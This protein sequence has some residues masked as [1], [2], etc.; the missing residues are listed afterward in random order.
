M[1]KYLNWKTWFVFAAICIVSATL[2]YTHRLAVQLAEEETK[3]MMQFVEGMRISAHTT[4]PLASEYIL[5]ILEQNTKIPMILTD[6]ED[7]ILSKTNLDTILLAKD[8]NYLHQCLADFKSQHEPLIIDYGFGQQRVYYGD[9]YLLKQLKYFPY[10]QLTIITLF[11]M[12]VLFALQAAHRSLQNQVWVG[13][14]KETA[15][16][17]GTP[18]S[19]IDAWLE[20]L[21]EDPSNQDALFEMQKDL[22]RLK[23]VADR[24]SKVGS[25]PQM[26]EENLMPRIRNMVQYM[27]KRAASKIHF[28]VETNE[29]EIPVYISG[30]LFDWVL[31]NLLRNA[32]DA[33]NGE[34]EIH[35]R[36]FNQTH[37]VHIDV[38]DTGKGIPP[39]QVKKI[40]KPGF[41]TKK[42]GWGLGLSLSKR[43]IEKYHHG[44]LFVKSSEPGKGT[45]FRIIIRR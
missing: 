34:G 31:E 25:T 9:S 5:S 43:I 33:L 28:E 21:K 22:D 20:I 27:Q 7:N 13:L 42:R 45:T 39:H 12:V 24:F 29:E 16:Q 15:H 3:N 8:T 30:A 18:L 19:S 35:I 38:S 6:E 4:D 1:R 26:E 10:I 14:S 37:N 44:S 2:Y 40:F 17:L 11:L 36:V 23:L 41:T 32:L